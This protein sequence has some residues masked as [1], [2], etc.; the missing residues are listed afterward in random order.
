VEGSAHGIV[1]G[2]YQHP[3]GGIEENHGRPCRSV[4]LIVIIDESLDLNT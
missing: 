2:A 1:S 3:P 4:E